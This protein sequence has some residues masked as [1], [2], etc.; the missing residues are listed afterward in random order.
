L[1]PSLHRVD[2]LQWA[3]EKFFF[4]DRFQVSFAL[5]QHALPDGVG[6]KGKRITG[7]DKASLRMISGADPSSGG[8]P[9][10]GYVSRWGV[11]PYAGQVPYRL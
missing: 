8:R 2:Q 5:G 6:I 11:D 1:I 7:P 10:P 9:E 4:G 3:L